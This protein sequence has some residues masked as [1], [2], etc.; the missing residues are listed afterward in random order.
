MN[1]L[2]RKRKD[3][4]IRE[5]N[6]GLG[7]RDGWT[8]EMLARKETALGPNPMGGFS[9]DEL[10]CEFFRAGYFD[11][12]VS[13]F[14][15]AVRF[16]PWK[17]AFKVHLARAYLAVGKVDEAEELAKAAISQDSDSPD[18]ALAMAQVRQR[19]GDTLEAIAWYERCLAAEPNYWILHEAEE[20]LK[21]L[22]A[23]G[24]DK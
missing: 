4:I 23:H 2:S 10:G 20:N 12:A 17:A 11:R 18:T 19:K 22:R 1:R 13:E 7:P 14:E 6:R 15:L 3:E 24:S 8:P 5:A 16:N 9:H 21:S